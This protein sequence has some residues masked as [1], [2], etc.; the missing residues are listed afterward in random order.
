MDDGSPTAGI[1]LFFC[2]IA[3][4][5]VFCGFDSALRNL[6]LKEAERRAIA[7]CAAIVNP[8]GMR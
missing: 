2:L 7:G 3:V 1:L 4:Y 8:A 6:N 5:A